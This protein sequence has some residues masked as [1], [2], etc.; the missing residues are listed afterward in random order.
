MNNCQVQRDPRTSALSRSGRLN[1]LLLTKHLMTARVQTG[2][3]CLFSRSLGAPYRAS[4][5]MFPSCVFTVCGCSILWGHRSEFSQLTPV[6]NAHS[7]PH[8][9]PAPRKPDTTTRRIQRLH[10]L[11]TSAVDAFFFLGGYRRHACCRRTF[12]LER[13]CVRAK[14][15]L[16]PL[17]IHP[18][19]LS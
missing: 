16:Q 17:R 3:H 6:R 9:R 19:K 7:G 13:G 15:F 2:V 11:L 10:L 8:E 4:T 12:V 14:H 5:C 18:H 1:A